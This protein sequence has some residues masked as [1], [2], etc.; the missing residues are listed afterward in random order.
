[1][2]WKKLL[3]AQVLSFLAVSMCCSILAAQEVPAFYKSTYEDVCRA[4]EAVKK[5]VVHLETLSAGQQ[6]GRAH[7]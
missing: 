5:G 7:V 6:I 1:M 2:S 3:K 4:V